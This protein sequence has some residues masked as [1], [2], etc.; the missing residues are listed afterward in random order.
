MNDTRAQAD[1]AATTPVS[2]SP[3]GS[4]SDI[5]TFEREVVR[6]ARYAVV[7][8]APERAHTIW[9]VLHGYGQLAARFVRHFVDVVP[10]D[11]C[12]VAPEGLSRFYLDAPS[13]DGAHLQRVGATWLTREAREL[14]I[15]DTLRWLDALHGDVV[16]A[17]TQ[18]RGVAPAIGVLGFSQGVATA[19]RWIAAGAVAPSQLVIWA[20]GLAHDADVAALLAKLASATVTIVA[21]R[22]DQ[23]VSDETLAHML[24]QARELQP[25]ASAVQF[26]GGHQL[27][28]A[29]LRAVL[30]AR[31][32]TAED[33]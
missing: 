22:R 10:P 23:F 27:D 12:I 28:A 21:G 18:A 26:D 1:T 29:T 4:A 13:T 33:G 24:V 9:F 7:G 15:R 14:E 11:T 25:R 8:A 32:T 3:P 31:D 6:T 19:M 17:S 16:D 2:V 30:T 5:R 20:G